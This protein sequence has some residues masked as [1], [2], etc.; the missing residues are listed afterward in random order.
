MKDRAKGREA[1]QRTHLVAETT[2]FRAFL[3]LLIIRKSPIKFVEW[4]YSFA[5][6][7]TDENVEFDVVIIFLENLLK[8]IPP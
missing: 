7:P 2:D 4:G 6:T 3:I 1:E 5:R 8:T